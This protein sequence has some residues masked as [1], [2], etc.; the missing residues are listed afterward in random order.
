MKTILLEKSDYI[1][2]KGHDREVKIL[3]KIE[4][5]GIRLLTISTDGH[6]KLWEGQ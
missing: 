4:I 5:E 1:L 2:F 3:A 6:I